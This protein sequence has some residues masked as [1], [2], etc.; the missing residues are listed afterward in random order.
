MKIYL[1][2]KKEEMLIYAIVI[3]QS[4]KLKRINITE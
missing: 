4:H 2:K 1:K 3:A